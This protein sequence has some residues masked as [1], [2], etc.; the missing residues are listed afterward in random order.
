M[1]TVTSAPSTTAA[2]IAATLLVL[3]DDP[4][5]APL[6]DRA[7]VP[8]VERLV[9][10]AAPLL[11]RT[12]TH[13]PWPVVR[14]LARRVERLLS[15][16]FSAHYALRKQAVR[17]AVARAVVDDGFRQVVLLGAGF[18]MLSLSV[19]EPATVFELDHP[20]TQAFKRRAVGECSPRPVTYVPV[21]L[22]RTPLRVALGWAP[23]FDPGAPTVFVA[24]GLV[25]Y[26]PRPTVASLLSD[27]ALLDRSRLVAS[28]VTPDARRRPDAQARLHSQS[29]LVDVCM[30]LIHERMLWSEPAATIPA[31]M[32]RSGFEVTSMLESSDVAAGLGSVGELALRRLPK[33][34]GEL[35]VSADSLGPRSAWR[36]AR[37]R[38]V[39]DAALA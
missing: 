13:L 10:E 19:P 39:S 25:M 33:A 23:A 27:A 2:V 3:A 34:P 7:A 24:E 30:R 6:V 26:L 36:E 8:Y 12:L 31:L 1:E 18:D 37:R 29:R 9:S 32:R 11:G 38:S 28:I 35:V 14:R 5:L 4:E 15:P 17:N 16:G 20:Q 21:D 22:L